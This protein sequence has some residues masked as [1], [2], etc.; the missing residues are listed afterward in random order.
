MYTRAD[1]QAGRCLYISFWSTTIVTTTS[2]QSGPMRK[3]NKPYG[4][5]CCCVVDTLKNYLRKQRWS[6]T[7]YHKVHICKTIFRSIKRIF[8]HLFCFFL[9]FIQTLALP[10]WA[11]GKR[12]SREVKTRVAVILHHWRRQ[13]IT[14]KRKKKKKNIINSAT[15]DDDWW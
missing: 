2:D 8:V 7:G 15:N 12:F 11:L 6:T 1:Y 3:I 14:K 5:R 4:N 13:P 10:F 9:L